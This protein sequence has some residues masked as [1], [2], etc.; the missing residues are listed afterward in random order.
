MVPTPAGNWSVP[1]IAERFSAASGAPASCTVPLNASNVSAV[2]GP[3]VPDPGEVAS[4]P[5]LTGCATVPVAAP[6]LMSPVPGVSVTSPTAALASSS[7]SPASS[8]ST[9]SS[10]S[11]ARES[12]RTGSKRR[13]DS[14]PFVRPGSAIGIG[15]RRGCNAGPKRRTMPSMNDCPPMLITASM[16]AFLGL[17][18]RRAFIGASVAQPPNG[19]RP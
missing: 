18:R 11:P 12:G 13:M 7:T 10:I 9:S 14:V 6:R 5:F 8:N 4:V 1:A 3:T 19:C 15:V 16:R 2:A 17:H